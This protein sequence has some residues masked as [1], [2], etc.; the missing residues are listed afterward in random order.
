M[1]CR[2]PPCMRAEPTLD[3]RGRWSPF[4]VSAVL[5]RD[6]PRG[7]AGDPIREVEEKDRYDVVEKPEDARGCFDL[8]YGMPMTRPSVSQALRVV[9]PTAVAAFVASRGAM[10]GQQ[11]AARARG[12]RDKAA[13]ARAAV[14]TPRP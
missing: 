14:P 11:D 8:G 12:R 9:I 13:R 5:T 1:W 7:L 3:A 2:P 6:R 10:G 4:G